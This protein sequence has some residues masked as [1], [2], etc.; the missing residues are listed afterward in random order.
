MKTVI[1]S[2]L[3][4]AA[5]LTAAPVAAQQVSTGA[6]SAIAHFNQDHDSQD[7]RVALD[8]ASVDAGVDISTRSDNATSF[9]FARFNQDADTQDGI[10]GVNGATTFNASPA[11][12]AAAIFDDIRRQNLENE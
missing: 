1:A 6:A 4:A 8:V 11:S 9:A 2:A 7:N 12:G 3:V 10:R 5:A